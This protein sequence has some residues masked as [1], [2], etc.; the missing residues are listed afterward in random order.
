MT[1]FDDRERAEWPPHPARVFSMLVAVLHERGAK[2]SIQ[3]GHGGGHTRADITGGEAPIAPS[4]LGHRPPRPHCRG[5]RVASK[6]LP[7]KEI[8]MARS[9]SAPGSYPRLTQ[10]LVREIGTLR[11]ATWDEALEKLDALIAATAEH[12]HERCRR[13]L[14]EVE[15]AEQALDREAR[16]QLIAVANGYFDTLQLNDGRYNSPY[17]LGATLRDGGAG[18]QAEAAMANAIA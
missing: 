17:P 3:L 6:L 12:H 9:K 8:G 18:R 13:I 7:N 2:V 15:D 14:A 4:V 1:Q 10:P 11:Q 16:A 5:S